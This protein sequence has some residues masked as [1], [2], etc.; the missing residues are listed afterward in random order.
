MV[1]H[2]ARVLLVGEV[3]R[4]RTITRISHVRNIACT[5]TA[6]VRR[7]FTRWNYPLV[8]RSIG[9]PRRLSSVEVNQCTV[10][11]V[12]R[13]NRIS[14]AIHTGLQWAITSSHQRLINGKEEVTC[15]ANSEVVNE[16]QTHRLVCLCKDEWT[17]VM[18]LSI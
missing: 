11:R 6:L 2:L 10:F 18:R 17:K 9:D 16:L 5:H 1:E 3:V 7:R 4:H 15:S 8:W 12:L 13:E 14:I